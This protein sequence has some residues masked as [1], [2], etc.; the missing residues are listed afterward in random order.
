[1]GVSGISDVD[2]LH[3]PIVVTDNARASKIRIFFLLSTN[4]IL[5]CTIASRKIAISVK[6][7]LSLANWW[8]K[9]PIKENSHAIITYN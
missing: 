9:I 3:M 1:M 2:H 4:E 5:C 6:K 8:R 7:F